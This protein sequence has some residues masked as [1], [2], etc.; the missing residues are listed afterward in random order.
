MMSKWSG[1]SITA[2]FHCYFTFITA[3]SVPA[4]YYFLV[5]SSCILK[6]SQDDASNLT[7]SSPPTPAE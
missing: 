4:I 5:L 1:T 7:T 3:R 6:R 2:E